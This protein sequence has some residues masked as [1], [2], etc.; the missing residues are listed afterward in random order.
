MF[1]TVEVIKPNET[2]ELRKIPEEAI[3][4]RCQQRQDRWSK[5]V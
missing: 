2:A 5:Y 4:Q 3:R 1:H